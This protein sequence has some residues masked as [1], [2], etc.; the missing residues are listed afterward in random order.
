[1]K[2][3]R[4]CKV[5]KDCSIPWYEQI[6][7]TVI[8]PHEPGEQ[9]Y[10]TIKP[11]DYVAILARTPEGK[12]IIVRQYR[13]AIEDYVYE[14]PSGHLEKG[15]TPE[16]AIIRELNEETNCTARKVILLGENY[17]DTGRLENRQWAFY[18]DDVEVRKFPAVSENEGIEVSLVSIKEL[19]NMINEGRFRHALDLCV[20][21]MSMSKG[22]LK[23]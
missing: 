18:S 11:S 17:P 12:V 15:E 4:I 8:L 10:Y 23:I 9:T 2:K 1:M 3:P 5:Q 20:I 16:Q 6:K 13:P 21:A 19:V 22:L 7:K 14:L